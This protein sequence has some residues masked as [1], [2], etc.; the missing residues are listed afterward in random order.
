MA[1]DSVKVIDARMQ[2]NVLTAELSTCPFR[3]GEEVDL[4]TAKMRVTGIIFWKLGRIIKMRVS[5]MID[6]RQIN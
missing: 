1:K 6:K 3:E 4:D 5:S 2:G